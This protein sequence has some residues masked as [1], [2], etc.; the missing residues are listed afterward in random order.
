MRLTDFIAYSLIFYY[1]NF[2]EIFRRIILWQF[3]SIL[4]LWFLFIS[5]D[6]EFNLTFFISKDGKFW[7]VLAGIILLLNTYNL[8]YAAIKLVCFQNLELSIL[9]FKLKIIL[10]IIFR[11]ILLI[12]LLL[13]IY[14]G[15]QFILMIIVFLIFKSFFYFYLFNES[16]KIMRNESFVIPFWEKLTIGFKSI[17][18]IILNRT[19]IIF[20]P[21]IATFSIFIVYQFVRFLIEGSTFIFVIER[22]TEIIFMLILYLTVLLVLNPIQYFSLMIFYK[23]H[24]Q[25]RI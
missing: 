19:L 6:G 14:T 3:A 2:R 13:S 24:S 10:L 4:L 21:F 12:S 22:T 15:Y 23:K 18:L 16:M 17:L 8:T 11:M 5:L 1:E 20:V 25:K 7:L 9:T